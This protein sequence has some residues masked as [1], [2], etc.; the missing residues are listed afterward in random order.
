MNHYLK[1]IAITAFLSLSVTSHAVDRQTLVR[2]AAPLK[3]LKK[4]QLKN[5]LHELMRQKKVLKYGGGGTGTWWGFWFT[6]RNP[7]TNEC[8]NRYSDAK[9][10]FQEHDGKSIPGMNIEHSF[11]KS[12]WGKIENDAWKDLYN[13]YPS[14]SKANSDKS[15]YPM[16]KVTNVTKPA[17]EGYD[18]VGQGYAGNQYVKMWEPGD[19][20]KGEFSR[21]YLYMATTYQDLTWEKTGLQ[22]LENNTWP[23]FQ[24]WAYSLYLKWSKADRVDSMEIA[25]NNAA[26]KIQN[27]RNLYVDF[28][29]LA[30]YVW[31]D[32]IDVPFDPFV[33]VTTADD[34]ARYTGVIVTP[35]EPSTPVNP[36][37]T[38]QLRTF[39]KVN[40]M[41]EV[42]KNYVMA[43]KNGDN[44]VVAKTLS[45]SGKKF[46]Y[47]KTS[48]V[49]S[50]D[51]KLKV[52]DNEAIFMLEGADNGYYIKDTHNRYFNQQAKYNTFQVANSKEGATTWTI[53]PRP[54][55][56]FTIVSTTNHTVQYSP[57]YT[58]FGAYAAVSEDNIYPMLYVE[59]V[60]DG[61]S[62]VAVNLNNTD[63]VYTLQGVRIT[64]TQNLAPGVYIQNGKKFIV[65]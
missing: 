42:G 54:D 32:S 63:A 22:S 4:E 8:Y 14:D 65:K 9:F 5:A 1:A 56:T 38:P 10:Y 40:V 15:N 39:V 33:S 27:N 30:E 47:L 55:G 29:N 6:D 61:I 45:T 37:P 43:I 28:P 13:L 2:Y 60:N 24:K 57:K 44:V 20:F 11:P 52:G 34:D 35:S 18:K 3:G 36:E 58:S 53:T 46:G 48:A 7:E 50:A 21:S 26:A 51:D 64:D 23:T 25:R 41:P 31:G 17:G 16:G 12:W 59:T 49:S 62:V 19:R